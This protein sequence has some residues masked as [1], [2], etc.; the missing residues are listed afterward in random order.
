MDQQRGQDLISARAPLKHQ[1]FFTLE[2]LNQ[3]IGGLLADINGR[4]MKTYGASRV[5]LLARLDKPGLK[6]LPWARFS[7]G[8][9]KH[10][11]VNIDYHVE[12]ERHA[13]SVPHASIVVLFATN[14]ESV[15]GSKS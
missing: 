1:T 2:A 3:R 8:V 15:N 7:V 13:Y 4:V 6:L 11:R 12:V 14:V 9:W 5:E 10:G